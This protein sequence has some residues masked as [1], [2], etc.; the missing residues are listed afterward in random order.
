VPACLAKAEGFLGEDLAIDVVPHQTEQGSHLLQARADLVYGL[1]LLPARRLCHLE[2]GVHVFADD[3][4]DP[5]RD[6][7][8]VV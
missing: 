7:L 3:T 5:V 4:F 1:V 6:G 8:M 2:D